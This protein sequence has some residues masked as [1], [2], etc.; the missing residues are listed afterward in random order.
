MWAWGKLGVEVDVQYGVLR[1][2]S[3]YEY[4]NT[5]KIKLY[6]FYALLLFF[7]SCFL[8]LNL[9]CM[10]FHLIP[11]TVL[12]LISLVH[13]QDR[14]TCISYHSDSRTL[15]EKNKCVIPQ[16]MRTVAYPFM[17]LVKTAFNREMEMLDKMSSA[18]YFALRD[19]I[20]FTNSETRD[21]KSLQSRLKFS[22]SPLC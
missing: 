10:Y 14:F 11:K 4:T 2:Y 17:L 18:S 21:W 7:F 8:F 1:I 5:D 22:F 20:C 6:C 9:M 3:I 19:C 13:I 12:Y 16:M 15:P